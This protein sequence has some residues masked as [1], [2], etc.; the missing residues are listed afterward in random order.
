[1][2][3]QLVEDF[4][5][6]SKRRLAVCRLSASPRLG[7]LDHTASGPASAYPLPKGLTKPTRFQLADY[8]VA[9]A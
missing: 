1:V 5:S 8:L 6:V 9:S 4:A 7:L 3:A 2:V